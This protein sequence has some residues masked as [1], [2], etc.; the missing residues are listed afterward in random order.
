MKK[1]RLVMCVVIAV[2]IWPGL[3]TAQN[4]RVDVSACD[5]MFA[6]LS[7]M[8]SHAPRDSV[9]AMLDSALNSRPYQVMFSHYNRSWRPN[10]LPKVVFKR[11]ILNLEF[12]GEYRLGENQRADQMLPF[13]SESYNNL[14]AFEVNV[15]Q[16]KSVDLKQLINDG[17]KYAQSW[18]PPGWTIPD[19][20]F[21]ILPNGGSP[22]FTI[23]D[24]Q[25]YDFFQLPRDSSNNIAWNE[26]VG[27]IS[28]ESFHLGMGGSV[29]DSLTLSSSDSL[30]L[31]FIGLFV[32]EGTATKFID[33]APG[34]CVPAVDPSRPDP[35]ASV[36]AADWKTYSSEELELFKLMVRTFDEIH[37]GE[38]SAEDVDR[39]FRYWLGGKVG[40]AYFLGSE[41]FGAIY[42]AIGREQVFAAMRDPRKLFSLYN[43]A[44][45]K[46]AKL[47]GS[48]PKIPESTALNALS[49]SPLKPPH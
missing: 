12:P 42:A 29:L 46:N 40:P 9:S 32:G 47:L 3:P 4:I 30:A 41:L 8:K 27:T 6:V 49:I 45:E 34:G 44:I 28:H 1:L 24:A 37:R 22:A 7:R 13:W 2:A 21:F 48:C 26:L 15:A 20:H 11:M 33:N 25:G 36:R 14:T 5:L 35:F 43:S 18:L 31:R 19:F 17:V 39:E 16:V 38:L 10:H 23:G